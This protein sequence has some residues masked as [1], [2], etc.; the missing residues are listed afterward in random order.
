[1]AKRKKNHNVFLL[2]W[3]C[4]GLETVIDISTVERLY[5]QEEQERILKILSDPNGK[6]PGNETSRMMGQALTNIMTRARVNSQRHYEIYTVH[7]DSSVTKQD[8]WEMFEQSPQTAADLI[9]E[10]GNKLYSDRAA[11]APKIL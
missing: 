2:S 5:E 10:H 3:D 1:M 9:R 4:N 7:T 8:M 11:H 6:D